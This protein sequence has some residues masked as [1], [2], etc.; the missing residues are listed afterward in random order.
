[1]ADTSERR[2]ESYGSYHLPKPS[3]RYFDLLADVT[4][5]RLWV[6]GAA[7][8]VV[9][10]CLVVN[11][12]LIV[13][14][15]LLWLPFVAPV[16]SVNGHGIDWVIKK[17][18][19]RKKRLEDGVELRRS[20]NPL[21]KLNK[22]VG[23]IVHR[24]P[25]YDATTLSDDDERPQ[26]GAVY[27]PRTKTH[28]IIVE[29]SEWPHVATEDEVKR[30]N[31]DHHLARVIGE[32]T[33][34]ETKK[35]PLFEKCSFYTISRTASPVIDLAFV[36]RMTGGNPSELTE[37][38][39]SG[40]RE[41]YESTRDFHMM[42]AIQVPYAARSTKRAIANGK[43]K[44]VPAVSTAFR[45]LKQLNHAGMMVDIPSPEE[46]NA[47]HQAIFNPAD[48]TTADNLAEDLLVNKGLK[49]PGPFRQLMGSMSS[50]GDMEY[51]TVA[52]EDYL[53]CGESYHMFLQT[54]GFRVPT[55]NAGEGKLDDVY[56]LTNDL[57]EGVGSWVLASLI[58]TVEPMGSQV[59]KA[60]YKR[61]SGLTKE[62]SKTSKGSVI[63]PKE[64]QTIMEAQEQYADVRLSQFGYASISLALMVSGTSPDI[65][66]EQL[67][68]LIDTLRF[69]E[70]KAEQV[71]GSSVMLETLET[72]IRLR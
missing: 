19:S 48:R 6:S 31:S 10:V 57:L 12:L 21:S 36:D 68:Q 34:P 63:D 7:A 49:D 13:V 24:F 70:I 26:L 40:I 33:S 28:T 5:Q 20:I 9:L 17:H 53:R 58:L 22:S 72:M 11:P 50:Q 25:L 51:Y 52:T 67:N 42:F 66:Q 56:N 3:Q 46:V 71:H 15:I 55:Y 39:I 29:L 8:A 18:N 41:A 59:R 38:L 45:L 69:F 16:P 2:P 35:G 37:E 65:V 60:R 43:W 14:P 64:E 62:Y 4:P 23:Y 44:E 32:L 30:I 61:M 54:T 27:N 47:I 1:M